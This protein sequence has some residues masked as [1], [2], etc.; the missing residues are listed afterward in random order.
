VGAD[1]I[2]VMKLNMQATYAK[3]G[4]DHNLQ[5]KEIVYI[6]YILSGRIWDRPRLEISGEIRIL[7]LLKLPICEEYTLQT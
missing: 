2:N 1:E 3:L 5:L 4:S 7:M 6:F